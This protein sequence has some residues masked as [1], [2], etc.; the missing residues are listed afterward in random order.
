MISKELQE[1]DL[2][3]TLGAGSVTGL[4]DRLGEVLVERAR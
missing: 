1:G 3:L 2:A 4:S